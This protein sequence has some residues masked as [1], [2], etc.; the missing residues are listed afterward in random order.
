VLRDIATVMRG[1]IFAQAIGVV[2]LPILSRLFSPEAF[3]HY[4]L[5]IAILTFLLVLPTLRY[6]VALLRV[7]DGA[8][9]QALFRLCVWLCAAITLVLAVTAAALSLLEWP[10]QLMA[11]PFPVW[12]LVVG[13]FVGG[14]SQVLTTVATRQR[15][16]GSIANSKVTQGLAYV[17]SALA[18]GAL[19][20]T[21]SGLVLADLT[22]RVLLCAVLALWAWRTFAPSWRTVNRE[23]VV[24]VAC[25]YREYPIISTPGTMINVLGG[26]ITP[27]MI[28]ASFSPATSGQ[29]GLLERSVTL[30]LALVITSVGQVFTAQFSAELRKDPAVALAHFWRIE[31]YM[32]LLALAALAVLLVGG[33]WLFAFVFGADWHVAGEL[34]RLMAPAFATMLLSGP[35]HLVLT[36]LGHQKLQTVWEVA[37]LALVVALWSLVPR[38]GIGL[39]TAVGAYSAILVICNVAF[40]TLAFLAIR[41]R[42]QVAAGIGRR[43]D[44]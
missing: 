4:Q 34:A 40:V 21:A 7:D 33:P 11:L 31:V 39:N 16:F 3:G 22:G 38:Y 35:V 5:F 10:P 17:G 28:Y 12:L 2:A 20:P 26:T 44:A 37:R 6:E 9:F 41:R 19:A 30:P 25:K 27:V 36:I 1:T 29:Y 23:F 42:V 8:E 24:L 13:T 18:I 14:I 32:A 15:A 43:D